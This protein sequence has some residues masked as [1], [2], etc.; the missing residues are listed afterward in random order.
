[1]SNARTNRSNDYGHQAE[2]KNSMRPASRKFEGRR[3]ANEVGD[4]AA[5]HTKPGKAHK[6][7]ALKNDQRVKPE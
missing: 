1:M 7:R 4:A 5:N 3:S 2:D 6:K